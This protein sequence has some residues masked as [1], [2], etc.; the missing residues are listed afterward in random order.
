[1]R[2]DPPLRAL[3]A[4]VLALGALASC[5]S[6]TGAPSSAPVR[7]VA[8]TGILADL[9][10]QVGGD[11]VATD[12]IVPTGGDPH[13]YEPTPDDARKVAGA[14][15]LVSNGLLLEE[16]SVTKLVDSNAAADAVRV[17]LAEQAQRHGG[18]LRPLTED[19]GLEL[20]WLGLAAPG[21]GSGEV[22]IRVTGVRGPGRFAVYLTDA[23]GTPQIHVDSGD[24]L[25]ERDALTLP[26]GAHT[27]VNWAFGAP[28]RY[29][30]SLRGELPAG[31]G[32]EATVTF[33]VAD[34]AGAGP[35]LATGHADIAVDAA[36]GRLFLRTDGPGRLT[37]DQTV[38]SVPEAARTTVPTQA[39]YRF[40]GAAGAPLWVLPQAVIGKH[41]HGETDPHLWQSVTNARAYV[42]AIEQALGRTDP[43]GR[44]HYRANAARYL[45]ELDR[46]GRYTAARLATIPA[47][48]RRLVTTHDAF[49]YLAAEHGL[50]V[51]GFV[52]PTPGQ[53][54]SGRQ[55][56]E[57]AATIRRLRIPAVF[58][59]PNL[60]GRAD[61]LRRVAADQ[62]VRVC[63]LYG[64]ALDQ[65]VTTYLQLMRHNA[66]Q[67]AD[68]LKTTE[69]QR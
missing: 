63:V 6:G 40:L 53:E 49:G 22:R 38:L 62:R 23:L 67:L 46:L 20:L 51:V 33:A 21:T 7:A 26:V 19:P 42:R 1:M 57:L 24:G 10:S 3:A 43:A 68:C 54:P 25:T 41:V 5:T 44:A 48:N 65:R 15:V 55:V 34:P 52:V 39:R 36:T 14:D 28:G 35:V 8:S 59:E 60:A 61:V 9:V 30:V 16:R 17:A 12:T 18:H 29:Q 64:D 37:P 4:A 13:S 56:A 47:A 50:R 2:L 32:P 45:A 27:H 58:V 66:D 31:P 11:R 69:E